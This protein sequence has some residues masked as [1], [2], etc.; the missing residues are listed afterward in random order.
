MDGKT[1][2]GTSIPKTIGRYEV[3]EVIGKGSM[4]IVYK[5]KDP[6]IK[7]TVAIKV[8]LPEESLQESEAQV[9]RE[10]FF[11]E[12]QAAGALVHPNIVSIY[13][14]GL[15]GNSCYIA[16]EFVD[17]TNLTNFCPKEKLL[18][19]EK[20]VSVTAKICEA[21]DFA[22]QQGI[23]HRDIKPANIMITR[24]GVVKVTDFGIAGGGLCR[25][26]GR[27]PG[28]FPAP[29]VEGRPLPRAADVDRPSGAGRGLVDRRVVFGCGI[30]APH[31]GTHGR[32]LGRRRIAP[33][34]GRRSPRGS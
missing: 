21:L 8:T 9:Y 14:A 17:G 10:R 16:M 19:V 22:H 33:D 5:G 1:S 24:N 3:S 34:G 30:R 32:R 31:R 11:T 13:D 25:D 27:Q 23:I 4:G 20:V 26:R 18:P 29:H 7:R 6:Y 2:E 28:H 15:E 12:A